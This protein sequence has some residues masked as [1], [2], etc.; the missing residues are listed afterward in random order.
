MA[1][2]AQKRIQA[3]PQY[4]WEVQGNYWYGHGWECVTTATK[5]SEAW[6]HLKEYRENE[7]GAAFRVKKVR[8]AACSRN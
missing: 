3:V 5:L 7:P 1:E 4:E 8:V 6:E 2:V